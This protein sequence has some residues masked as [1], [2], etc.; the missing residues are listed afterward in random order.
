MSFEFLDRRARRGDDAELRVH[1]DIGFLVVVVLVFDV[2]DDLLDEVFDRHDAVR[3]PVLI[4]D[5]RHVNARRLH[6]DQQVDGGH[7]RRH[8]KNLAADFHRRYGPAKI[9]GL[10]IELFGAGVSVAPSELAIRSG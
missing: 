7:R 1:G 6:A 3:S 4:D 8:V 9:K 5:E 2:A 10:K